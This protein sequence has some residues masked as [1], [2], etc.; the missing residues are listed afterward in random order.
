MFTAANTY[1]GLLV[2]L[3][4]GMLLTRFIRS[5]L[6]G[7]EPN[8]PATMAA[9]AGLVIAVGVAASLRPAIRASRTDP[10]TALRSE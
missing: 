6:S 4:L 5:E 8:D 10:L 9:A 2:G 1:L 3:G 7:V